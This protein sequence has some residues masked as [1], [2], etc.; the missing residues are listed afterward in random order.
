MSS[1]VSQ[2]RASSAL[3]NGAR[4]DGRRSAAARA[5]AGL[6]LTARGVVLG[7][8]AALQVDASAG[9]PAIPGEPTR[10]SGVRDRVPRYGG[11][12]VC[13]VLCAGVARDTNGSKPGAA[14]VAPPMSRIGLLVVL[15]ALIVAPLTA[16]APAGWRLRADNST[17]A[18][19]P[20]AAGD[21]TFVARNPAFMQRTR[22]QRFSGVRNMLL[23]VR[24]R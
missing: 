20:D 24:T 22:A 3:T 21:I 19:D 1:A 13:R 16:Q 17:N 4:R 2:S 5:V 6:A 7:A 9:L 8:A 10:S 15:G 23:V 18:S 12:V 14:G 11:R